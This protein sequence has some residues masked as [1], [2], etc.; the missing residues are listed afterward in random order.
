MSKEVKIVV[1]PFGETQEL[2]FKHPCKWYF[3]CATGDY[4]YIAVRDRAT[5][6]AYVKEEWG[7]KYPVRC[8]TED[9]GNG[10]ESAVGRLSSK[11]RQGLRTRGKD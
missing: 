9:K 8:A 2:E 4:I 1:V 10:N 7:G 6:I 11:S 3:R 5:A